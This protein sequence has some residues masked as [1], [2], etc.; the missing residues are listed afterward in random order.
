MKPFH[1]TLFDDLGNA[2]KVIL[3]RE[4][5]VAIDNVGRGEYGDVVAFHCHCQVTSACEHLQEL[6]VPLVPIRVVLSGSGLRLQRWCSHYAIAA[7]FTSLCLI[8]TP[9]L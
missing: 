3:I 6:L 4:V 5:E 7:A 1:S 9:G 8:D 2:F